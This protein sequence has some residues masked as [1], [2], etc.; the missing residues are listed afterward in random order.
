MNDDLK[1]RLKGGAAAAGIFAFLILAVLI[2]EHLLAPSAEEALR[3]SVAETLAQG[4][5]AIIAP[6]KALPWES[7]STSFSHSWEALKGKKPAGTLYAVSVTGTAGPWPT[8]FFLDSS[9][10]VQ[11]AG[12]IGRPEGLENPVAYGLTPRVL[13]SWQE[14]IKAEDRRRRESK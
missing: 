13:H 8:V 3:A 10:T 7:S 6:G 1:R 11:F 2:L 5:L 12:I 4:S 14:R 9:G